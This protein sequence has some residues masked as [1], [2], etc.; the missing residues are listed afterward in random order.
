MVTFGKNPLVSGRARGIAKRSKSCGRQASRLREEL[1]YLVL[2][3]L[4]KEPNEPALVCSQ[5]NPQQLFPAE[6][7][8]RHL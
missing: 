8:G 7:P 6:E 1:A 2:E 3:R 5:D 4:G